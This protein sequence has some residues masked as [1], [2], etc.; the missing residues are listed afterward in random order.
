MLGSQRLRSALENSSSYLLGS[1]K[2]SFLFL[3][4][5]LL[6]V[7]NRC[8]Q[9]RFTHNKGSGYP[10]DWDWSLRIQKQLQGWS[11]NRVTLKQD[12]FRIL[13]S[14]L[15]STKD[16]PRSSRWCHPFNTWIFHAT[17]NCQQAP[18]CFNYLTEPV[19]FFDLCLLRGY[20]KQYIYIYIYIYI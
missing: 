3:L 14:S 11:P 6:I 9:E 15:L 4:C 12:N 10:G 5:V 19:Q 16:S 18:E 2:M 17:I 8:L 13:S 7:P 20:S 1:E